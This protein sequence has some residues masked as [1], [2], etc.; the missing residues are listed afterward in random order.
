MYKYYN[1]VNFKELT[2]RQLMKIKTDN[3]NFIIKK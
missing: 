3:F 1:K 2:L